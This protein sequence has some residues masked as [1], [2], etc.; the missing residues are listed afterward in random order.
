[1]SVTKTREAT[2]EITNALAMTAP[3][4]RMVVVRAY[5]QDGE[6]WHEI[7]PVLAVVGKDVT[8][9]AKEAPVGEYPDVGANHREMLRLGWRFDYR[10]APEYSVLIHD[11]EFG[12][13]ELTEDFTACNESYAIRVCPWP[14][15]E[16]EQRLA[17]TIEEVRRFALEKDESRQTRRA[18]SPAL[19]G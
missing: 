5:A 14:A 4:T 15:D 17:E 11:R 19:V 9:Y 13:H 7:V 16:D 8:G 10:F 6:A 18:S 12:I 1:M 2:R 3:A